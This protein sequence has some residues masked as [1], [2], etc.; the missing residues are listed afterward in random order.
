MVQ[1]KVLALPGYLQL[2]CLVHSLVSH[3]TG[4]LGESASIGCI[5]SVHG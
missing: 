4:D 3:H 1:E 5:I 2:H